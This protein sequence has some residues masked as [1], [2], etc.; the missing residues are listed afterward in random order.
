MVNELLRKDYCSRSLGEYSDL[1][2]LALI[3]TVP[4]CNQYI[5]VL[6]NLAGSPRHSTFI[7]WH[8]WGDPPVPGEWFLLSWIVYPDAVT[9]GSGWPRVFIGGGGWHWRGRTRSSLPN[10]I[11]Y[12]ALLSHLKKPWS[13]GAIWIARSERLKLCELFGYI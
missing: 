8:P 10:R 13:S 2:S 7:L 11:S 3:G 9:G 1:S 4:L 6:W 12:A 5:W